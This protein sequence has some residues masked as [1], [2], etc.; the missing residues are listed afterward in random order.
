MAHPLRQDGIVRT[1][2]ALKMGLMYVPSEPRAMEEELS[3]GSLKQPRSSKWRSP[4]TVVGWDEGLDGVVDVE[5]VE[6]SEA[7]VGMVK[8]GLWVNENISV[9]V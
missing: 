8:K 7:K 2:A 4:V 5:V 9:L 1:L 6:I 3:A